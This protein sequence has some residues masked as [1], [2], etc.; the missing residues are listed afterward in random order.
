MKNKFITKS[1]WLTFYSLACGYLEV[2]KEWKE[3]RLVKMALIN[4]SINLYLV[5]NYK[6]GTHKYCQS[7]KEARKVFCNI[8]KKIKQTGLLIKVNNMS[9][10]QINK[11]KLFILN[12]I[13]KLEEEIKRL[14]KLESKLK[15]DYSAMNKIEIIVIK[16][17]YDFT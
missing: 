14:K 11:E 5:D 3:N 6:T 16:Y 10:I 15:S 13:V 2:N 4:P 9:N 7:I 17:K 8:A 12:T 1:G